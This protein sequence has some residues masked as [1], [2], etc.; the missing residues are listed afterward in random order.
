MANNEFFI[1][2][3]GK[4]P[5]GLG[6]FLR[7][8]TLVALVTGAL[9]ALVLAASQGTIGLGVFEYGKV[10]EFEGVL[11]ATPV[12]MLVADEADAESGQSIYMLANPFK[13]GFDP[14]VASKFHLKPVVLRGTLIY[15]PNDGQA[16]IEVVPESVV[17]GGGDE[18]RKGLSATSLGRRTL[19]GEIVDSKCHIG[20]MNPGLGKAHRACAIRCISGGIAPVLLVRSEKTGRAT[21]YLLVGEDGEAINDEVLEM[22]ALP[23][24]ITGDVEKVG[25][26][27]V[28]K[29]APGSYKLL[30]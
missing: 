11:M 29:A 6:Q 14:A 10:K 24:E 23:V 20:V 13:F 5:E 2:W 18:M 19:W 8:K 17:A 1:G 7:A 26:R 21:Y 28:L 9:F 30:R 16:M 3:Q 25:P 22:V 12:P 27:L 4:A 15:Q